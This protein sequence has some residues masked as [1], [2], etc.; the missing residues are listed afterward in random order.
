[1]QDPKSKFYKDFREQLRKAG[2]ENFDLR[3]AAEGPNA[4]SRGHGQQVR[5]YQSLVTL[6]QN[7]DGYSAP[8][9]HDLADDIRSAEDKKRGGDPNMWDLQGTSAERDADGS[10]TTRSTA[11]SASCP[12]N[13]PLPPPTSTPGQTTRTTTSSTC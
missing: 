4:I 7:G 9:M 3:E 2:V 1:M 11:R 5:G 12:R 13:L 8:F 6:M 10:P